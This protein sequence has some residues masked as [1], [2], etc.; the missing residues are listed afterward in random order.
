MLMVSSIVC[1]CVLLG[2]HNAMPTF[3]MANYLVDYV[4]TLAAKHA[5]YAFLVSVF[6]AGVCVSVACVAA[7]CVLREILGHSQTSR[8]QHD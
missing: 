1:V 3:I 7:T 6:A 5:K 2:Q 4:F 8:M